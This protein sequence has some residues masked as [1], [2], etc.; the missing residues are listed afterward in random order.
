[1][2][3]IPVPN[4]AEIVL[5]GDQLGNDAVM[6]LHAEGIGVLTLGDLEAIA[7]LITDWYGAELSGILSNQYT[8]QSVKVTALDTDS[9]PVFEDFTFPTHV[10]GDA[11]A[12]AALQ[13][14]LVVTHISDLRGRN[15]RGRSFV[16]GIPTG[17][18]DADGTMQDVYVAAMQDAWDALYAAFN[19]SEYTL[20]V[21]SK[22]YLGAPRL[23]GLTTPIVRFRANQLAGTIR[24]R[25]A[26]HGA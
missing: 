25:V 17:C 24:S 7:T 10:G 19:A 5:N 23:I 2:P 21:V 16:P 3:F 13:N 18:I 20:V 14:A 1:M 6:V 26:G 8:L 4:T 9:S 15:F 11:R 12:I 22:V